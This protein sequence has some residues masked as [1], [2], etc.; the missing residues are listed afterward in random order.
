MVT[1]SGEAPL[2]ANLEED[3]SAAGLL[4]KGFAHFRRDESRAAGDAFQAAIDTGHLNDAGR[5]L[6]YWHIYL[7]ARSSGD[8]EAGVDALASFI[9]VG[10]DILDVREDMRYA[11]DESGDFVSRF[12]L[13]H[14]LARARA[15]LSATWAAKVH[16]FGRSVK[17]PVPIQDASE[18][19]Y[20]LE[21]APPCDKTVRRRIEKLPTPPGEP[22]HVTLTCESGPTGAFDY[23]FT[24]G[25]R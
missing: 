3:N 14:R 5:A 11:V 7:A 15:L 21:V 10:Q 4:E 23:Y 9:V 2:E 17:Q 8:L 22:T 6:A 1:P 16:G 25:A 24:L 13:E 18:M 20:F 19:E 12:D